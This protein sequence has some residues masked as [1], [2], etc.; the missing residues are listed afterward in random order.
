M[1]DSWKEVAFGDLAAPIRNAI[2]GGPFGSNLV[3]N[4][5]VESGVPVIRGQN[6]GSRWV[7]GDFVFVNEEK[8]T[9]LSGNLARTGD[10]VFTQRGTLGQVAIV[11]NGDHD[12]YLVSQSQMKATVDAARADAKFLYY[13]FS[14]EAQ[15]DWIRSN[16]I[17]TGV[18]HTNLG[19]LKKHPVLLP[20][21]PEQRA[22]A[23]VLGALDDKIEQNRRTGRA[24][25]G[26]V[27]ATFKAWFVDFEPVK[28]KAAGQTSF[29]GMPPATFAALPDSLTD[30]PLGPVPKGWEIRT[31]GDLVTVRGGGTPST[32][33]AE[34]W[35]GGVHFWATPKD[36]S[37][38]QDPVLLKTSRRI[39]DAGA[40]CISSGVLKE[41]TVLL[42]SRAPVGYTALA[43]V[44]VAVNQGFIAM[45]C[46]GPLPP[47]YVLHWTRSMLGEIKS[48]AS[49]TTFPEISKGAFRPI[50]AILPS[51]AVHAFENFAAS[52]FGLIE[53]NARQS[54]SLEEMRSYLLPRLLSGAVRVRL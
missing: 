42:S 32:K 21:L 41:N 35:D 31:I 53:A 22:I 46:D 8:A 18:P 12:Y 4:D 51:V 47:H 25:E 49:G 23:A 15:Q 11:P 10:L 36:L 48:R 19:I 17:Q 44:P 14:S 1:N 45:T 43:K 28:A 16:A 54:L 9:S 50:P 3:S 7:G 38:L 6:M 24:L 27:Q 20:S 40:E 30:S 13:F 2:V 34:Y 5:Y 37:G 26:L 39:T 52:L 33:V 29:P